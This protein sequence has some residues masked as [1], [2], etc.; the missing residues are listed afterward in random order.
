MGF[1]FS[2]VMDLFSSSKKNFK[3][4]ILGVQNAGKTTILYKLALG[5]LVNTKPTI[6]S[7]VEEISYNNLAFK[8]WDLGGQSSMRTVW[9]A[10]YAASDAII[11]VVDS[12]DTSLF[13]ESKTELFKLLEHEELKN[14]VLLVYANKQDDSRAKDPLELSQI[15]GLD[16]INTHTW[17]IQKCSA[18]SGEGLLDGFKWLSDQLVYQKGTRFPNNPYIASG[19]ILL[20]I[21]YNNIEQETKRTINTTN[22]NISQSVHSENLHNSKEDAIDSEITSKSSS[23]NK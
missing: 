9:D 5:Q 16:S 22:N 23:V 20:K 4:I 17:H 2:K 14:S 12:V 13:E 21:A 1:L 11:Y 3:I 6:G 18:K 19:I 10:Y 8:A 7:N 15:Y